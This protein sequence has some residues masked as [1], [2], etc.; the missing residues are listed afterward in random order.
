MIVVLGQF[1]MGTID[2][3][4]APSVLWALEELDGNRTEQRKLRNRLCYGSLQSLQDF[5]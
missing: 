2:W 5:D 4:G 3:P 1:A